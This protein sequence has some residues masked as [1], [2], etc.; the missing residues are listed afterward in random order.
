[1]GKK[2]IRE[3]LTAQTALSLPQLQDLSPGQDSERQQRDAEEV[4]RLFSSCPQGLGPQDKQGPAFPDFARMWEAPYLA[5]SRSS[6]ISFCFLSQHREVVLRYSYHMRP[7]RT[8]LTPFCREP[9]SRLPQPAARGV[10]PCRRV[11]PVQPTPFMPVTHRTKTPSGS[12]SGASLAHCKQQLRLSFPIWQWLALAAGLP[13]PALPVGLI[14][15][16]LIKLTTT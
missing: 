9:P 16:S 5:N 3:G 7:C 15:L 6:C 8:Q 4:V 1:M 14:L 13:T 11:L 10:P 12:G 2:N